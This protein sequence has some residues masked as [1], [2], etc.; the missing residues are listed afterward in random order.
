[1]RWPKAPEVRR[2]DQSTAASAPAPA[3][4]DG[5]ESRHLSGGGRL[6]AAWHGMGP[7]RRVVMAASI[8]AL[9]MAGGLGIFSALDAFGGE[10]GTQPHASGELA[11]E[12]GAG[13][14]QPGL[15]DGVAGGATEAL[16]ATRTS[17]GLPVSPLPPSGP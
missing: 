1:M 5:H 17:P 7:T 14:G 4:L 2:D 6:G 10:A 15:D 16:N 13:A 11:A 12:D 3:F 8:V 9:S